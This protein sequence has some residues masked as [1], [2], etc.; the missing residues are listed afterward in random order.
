MLSL[1]NPI[2]I[3]Q[4]DVAKKWAL[5]DAIKELVTGEDDTSFLSQEYKD[6]LRD[7]ASIKQKY[8]EQPGILQYM[9]TVI[10]DLYGDAAKI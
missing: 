3:R 7:E 9:R 10:A 2:I 5:I 4:L 8:H 6:I 1:L